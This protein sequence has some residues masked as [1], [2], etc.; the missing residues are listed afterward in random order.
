MNKNQND[1]SKGFEPGEYRK[2]HQA[3]SQPAH[4]RTWRQGVAILLLLGSTAATWLAPDCAGADRQPGQD[5]ERPHPPAPAEPPLPP[6]APP[7]SRWE[8][9]PWWDNQRGE[10]AAICITNAGAQTILLGESVLSRPEYLTV[11]S[12]VL[13][14]PLSNTLTLSLVK[15]GADHPLHVLDACSVHA[16][17]SIRVDNSALLVDGV[18]VIGGRLNLGRGSV[19][20]NSGVLV[21]EGPDVEAV[22]NVNGGTF[23]VTNSSHNARILI[24]L[25]GMG[26]FSLNGGNVQ[27]DSLQVTNDP[28][29]RFIFKSGSAKLRS[30]WVANQGPMT[31]G[32]GIHPATLELG[33]GTNFFSGLLTISSNATVLG[34][35]T[36]CGPVA[37]YGTILAG[38]DGDS[39]IF[40]S[41]GPYI[42]S[43]TNWGRMYMTNGGKLSF[44]G[45]ACNNVPFP[46][47]AMNQTG[48]GF[49][50]QFV[51]VGGLSHTLQY[52]SAPGD[53]NW[54]SVASVTG[55]GETLL[56]SDPAL[57]GQTRYYRIRVGR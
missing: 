53:A 6:D 50:A 5:R 1:C 20:A 28:N 11:Q 29:S 54:T 45:T 13:G 43:V 51:S 27:A 57:A 41:S 22:V 49:T 7:P 37:N 47:T 36:I 39:L 34:K 26:S 2:G 56:L 35:G 17:A 23:T 44:E 32:D 10:H 12:L 24:G 55:T 46:I 16:N 14:A 8:A 33:G 19:T 25:A 30:L 15:L 4:V 9:G 18:A 48:A 52:K 3:Q 21:G 38:R 31:V 40:A 42:S